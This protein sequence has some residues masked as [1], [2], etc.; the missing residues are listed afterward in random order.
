MNY[1]LQFISVLVT[2]CSIDYLL[3]DLYKGKYYLIHFINNIFI[4]YYTFLDVIYTFTEFN[5]NYQNCIINYSPTVITFSLHLYH[6]I[7]Y[8][9]KL[10][11]DDWL[12]HILMCCV[13]LPLTLLFNPG[14]LL[15]YSLFFLTGLPGGINYLL[16]FLTRNKIITRMTQ[17]TINT[18]LNLWIRLPGCISHTTITLLYLINNF[19]DFYLYEM[20]LIMLI[21]SIVF[22][23]GIYFM[24]QV[25]QNYA[26]CKLQE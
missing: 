6:T 9:K 17:K 16:L 15:G 21:T 25:V 22:W 4:T 13:A 23:N 18:S 19:H 20:C 14:Y 24:N 3:G 7:I 26:I 2:Y 10:Q 1:F 8:Y 12:H 5:N 11:F